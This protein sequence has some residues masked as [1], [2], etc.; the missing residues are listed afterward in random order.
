[1]SEQ[2]DRDELVKAAKASLS[3]L[4]V[5]T[6]QRRATGNLFLLRQYAQQC[7]EVEDAEKM[8]RDE[9]DGEELESLGGIVTRMTNSMPSVPRS[10][11]TSVGTVSPI[12]DDDA[13]NA[14]YDVLSVTPA[15]GDDFLTDEA[16]TAF[17]ELRSNAP[18]GSTHEKSDSSSSKG[19]SN[20]R[21]TPPTAPRTAESICPCSMM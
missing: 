16:T 6:A 18:S 11:L 7:E 20:N 15:S 19:L 12:P 1:M 2:H 10:G 3:V 13:S 14:A 9:L 4:A 21:P 8:E 5:V 17:H